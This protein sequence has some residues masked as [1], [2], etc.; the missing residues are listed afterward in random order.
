MIVNVTNTTVTVS[1]MPPNP[2]NGIISQYQIH[3]RSGDGD[4]FVQ[5]NI[6]NN[7][8]IYTVTGLSINTKYEFQVR[9]FTII[10]NG[11]FSDHNIIV[12]PGKFSCKL[13]NHLVMLTEF[14]VYIITTILYSYVICSS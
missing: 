8:L 9:A 3:Y 10:G 12:H 1:W 6:T 14:Y 13:L 11:P 4:N 7:V 2:P 5:Q